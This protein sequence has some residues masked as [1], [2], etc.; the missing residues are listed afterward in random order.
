MNLVATR[1]LPL[2]AQPPLNLFDRPTSIFTSWLKSLPHPIKSMVLSH[3][4]ECSLEQQFLK[5]SKNRQVRPRVPQ[6]EAIVIF[7]SLL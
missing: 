5:V 1:K 4:P 3:V 2:E 6:L 7:Q